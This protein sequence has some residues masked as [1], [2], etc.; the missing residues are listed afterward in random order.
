V[1]R[2]TAD[3]WVELRAPGQSPI[4]SRILKRGEIYEVPARD[5]LVLTTGNAGGLEI[6]LDG[7]TLPPLGPM[8]A[9][10]R[11][12]ALNPDKLAAVNR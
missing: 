6:S 10:Q 9:V 5:D 12:F 11:G 2:A 8:G 4:V 3:S 7:K 1:L